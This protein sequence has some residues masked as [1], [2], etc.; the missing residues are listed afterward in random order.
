MMR[1]SEI[2]FLEGVL[3]RSRETRKTFFGDR[4]TRSAET[5]EIMLICYAPAMLAEIKRLRAA[6]GQTAGKEG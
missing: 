6:L 4:P 3:E 2:R 5:A 1:D